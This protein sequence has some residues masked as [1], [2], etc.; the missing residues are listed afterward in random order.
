M[1]LLV[2]PVL[3]LVSVLL[4]M[5]VGREPHRKAAIGQWSAVRGQWPAISSQRS[6]VSD[7]WS[8]GMGML[9]ISQPQLRS[10]LA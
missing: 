9:A 8:A 2:L 10:G 7:Q 3:V 6:E 1:Q 4:I 5:L